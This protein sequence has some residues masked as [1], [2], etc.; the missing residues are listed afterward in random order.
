MKLY[1]C[2]VSQK[3]SKSVIWN[4]VALSMFHCSLEPSDSVGDM[5]QNC[6]LDIFYSNREVKV[7]G[8]FIEII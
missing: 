5:K 4:Y 3:Y 7:Q 6:N 2:N 1:Q 8:L